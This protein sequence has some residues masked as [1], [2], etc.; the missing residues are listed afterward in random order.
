MPTNNSILTNALIAKE[1]LV[2]LE[3]QMV[4]GNLVHRNR[5]SKRG[6]MWTMTSSCA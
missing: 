4:L 1:A 5:T 6:P 2:Q 3:N